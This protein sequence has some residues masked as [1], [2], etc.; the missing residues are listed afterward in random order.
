MMKMNRI[1]MA[2]VAVVVAV[3]AAT[4]EATRCDP[5]A[6]QTTLNPADDPHGN[7]ANLARQDHNVNIYF[8]KSFV[9]LTGGPP[10]LIHGNCEGYYFFAIGNPRFSNKP[11]D[12][13]PDTLS[14]FYDLYLN[15]R[16]RAD[17]NGRF[18][19]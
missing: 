18:G 1:L 15:R 10:S 2:V 19:I 8:S 4:V 5:A 7:T 3:A 6:V 14:A 13:N 16:L 17:A 9:W 11:A 12:N